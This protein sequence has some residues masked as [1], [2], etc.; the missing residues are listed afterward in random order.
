M[1][2]FHEQCINFNGG[3]SRFN[4][5]PLKDVRVLIPENRDCIIKEIYFITT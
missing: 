4:D 5:G 2:S 1:V 3:S